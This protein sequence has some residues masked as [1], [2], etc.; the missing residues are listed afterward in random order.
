MCTLQGAADNL[1]ASS[2]GGTDDDAINGVNAV[3]EC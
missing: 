2:E 3:V 1:V